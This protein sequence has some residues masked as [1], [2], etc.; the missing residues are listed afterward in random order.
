MPTS[1]RKGKHLSW[2]EREGIRAGLKNG[3]PFGAI[4]EYLGRD[5]TTI[6]KEV[7]RHR[8][9]KEVKRISWEN[10]CIHREKCR[11][12]DLCGKPRRRKCIIL[13]RTC[14]E[15]S[16][17]CPD[18]KPGTCPVE[19][20]PPYV[21]NGCTKQKLCRLDRYYYGPD[22]AQGEYQRLLTDSRR[23]I[24]MTRDELQALDELV[25]PLVRRGQSLS[26]IY[27]A[28]SAEIP[29]SIRTPY[30]YIDAQYLSV[31]NLDMR[32]TVRYRPRRKKS[33]PVP[34]RR[35]EGRRYEDFQRWMEEHPGARVVEMDTVEGAKGSKYLL[36]LLD[37]DTRLMLAF[38]LPNKE[39]ETVLGILDNLEERL[40]TRG[41]RE[42]FPLLLTDN[43]SEFSDPVRFEAGRDGTSRTRIF[44]CEPRM[45]NQKGALEKNHEYIRYILPK[46]TPFDSLTDEKVLRMVNHV[47]NTTRP[48]LGSQTPMS[49]ALQTL[50]AKALDSLGLCT[51]PPDDVLLNQ[52]LIRD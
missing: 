19:K 5:P 30:R 13:C 47:N 41:F 18:Y 23:G 48:G 32:R 33:Q 45:S 38:L 14:L 51:I 17:H 8:F 3:L 6:A 35:K 27:A 12:R 16:R 26:H 31:K 40:G 10:D 1:E 20:R 46:G 24:D 7:R 42:L 39:M 44:Y 52:D 43:G 37:R 36:T 50:D 21:C 25:S 49:L 28:H 29:V 2:D 9:K 22:G 15:C 4:A 34:S 11:K